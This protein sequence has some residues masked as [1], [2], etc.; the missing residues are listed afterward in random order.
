MS[1]AIISRRG[2]K[3]GGSSIISRTELITVNQNWVV[4]SYTG[5][6]SVRIFGGGGAGYHNFTYSCGGFG[7]YMN[8]SIFTN[9]KKGQ[10]VTITIGRGGGRAYNSNDGSSGGTTTFGSYLSANGGSSGRFIGGSGGSGGGGCSGS[11]IQFGGGGSR[12]NAGNGGT[13]GGGGSCGTYIQDIGVMS[14]NLVN[15]GVYGRG[16]TYGGDGGRFSLYRTYDV[17]ISSDS[18]C[19]AQDGTNTMSI[20]S[21]PSNCRGAGKAG[22]TTRAYNSESRSTAFVGGGGGGYGGNGGDGKAIISISGSEAMFYGGGGGGGGYG[23][24]GGDGTATYLPSSG[25]GGGYGRN[26]DGGIKNGGGGGYFSR[27]G[28]SIGGGGGYYARGGDGD[29]GGG[30]GYGNGGDGSTSAYSRDGGYGAG[31]GAYGEGGDGICII[32]YYI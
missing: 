3:E 4:P 11:A 12:I 21:V 14:S 8:N 1:E 18:K 9:L 5:S 27:G 24:N 30:G 19:N 28:D 31:G 15:I 7:G 10:S 6:I 13:Y 17:T 29:G 22:I 26:A 23:G 25:G 20:S 32:Q 16:G 2:S